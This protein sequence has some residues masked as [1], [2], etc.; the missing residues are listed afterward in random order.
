M[1]GNIFICIAA[2]VIFRFTL[3]IAAT[4]SNYLLSYLIDYHNCCLLHYR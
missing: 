1:H 2:L 4:N 3:V